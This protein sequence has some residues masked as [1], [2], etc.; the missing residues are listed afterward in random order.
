MSATQSLFWLI[1]AYTTVSCFPCVA[2]PPNLP[3]QPPA[4]LRLWLRARAVLTRS[5]GWADVA[6][7][8]AAAYPY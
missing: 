8:W 6:L 3:C 1:A 4:L 2:L 7:L 5:A